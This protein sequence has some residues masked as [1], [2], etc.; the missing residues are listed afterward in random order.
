MKEA[1]KG[2]V[3]LV[4][5]GP[6]DP[7]LLTVRA[8]SL[9]RTA[10]C[11][12]HDDLVSP[13]VLSLARKDAVIENVGKRS[14]T[15]QITQEQINGLLIEHARVGHSVVR[16]KSG[17]PM[18]FGRAAEEIEA[19]TGASVPFEAVPGITAGFAAASSLRTSLSDRQHA[20]KVIFLTGHSAK[21]GDDH[22][23]GKLPHD[24]TLVIYMPGSDYA[25]LAE[26][27]A[28]AGVAPKTPC[29]VVSNVGTPREQ[30]IPT[31]LQDLAKAAPL[32]APCVVLVG[33]ALRKSASGVGSR[34]L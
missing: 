25:R 31:K 17:D 15:K 9:L 3:Y 30:S 28:D 24:A 11:V 7:D 4:G 13:E 19:L 14:G 16:L 5:A 20:S 6:G 12:F 2:I 32:P 29:I 10:D 23:W 34:A 27:L 33:V 21:T 26:Q 8:S 22:R 1:N 18:V